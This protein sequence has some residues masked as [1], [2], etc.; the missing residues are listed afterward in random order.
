VAVWE[1]APG[2]PNRGKRGELSAMKLRYLKSLALSELYR[3]A[4]SGSPKYTAA[5]AWLDELFYGREYLAESRL[6]IGRLPDLR[7]PTSDTELFEVENTIALHSALQNLNR[8]QAA[9]DRLWSWLAHGPYWAYMRKRWPVEG[10]DNKSGYIKEHYLLGGSRSLVRH[11]LARLW[12]FGHATYMP[13][14]ADPYALTRLLLKTTDARQS[15]MERQFWRNQKILHPFLRR[16]AHWVDQGVDLYV[17]RERFRDLC[18]LMN[19]TG[20]SA[21]LDCFGPREIAA[22]VDRYAG[23]QQAAAA[24][25]GGGKV[26]AT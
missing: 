10:I 19:L 21:V 22:V 12:W 25:L 26:S 6:D 1:S 20:G 17:P 7:Q 5:E 16:I 14:A 2:D 3:V 18:K 4:Q 13:G 24:N 8:S 15:I 11:G 9:D 23:D